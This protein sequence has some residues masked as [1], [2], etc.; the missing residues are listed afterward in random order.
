MLVDSASN[1]T[2]VVMTQGNSVQEMRYDR[3]G[4]VVSKVRNRARISVP[5][6]GHNRLVMWV[7]CQAKGMLRFDLTRG[8]G[9]TPTSHGLL[10]GCGLLHVC[11]VLSS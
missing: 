4:V 8:I 2:P 1:C 9:L 6:C 7:T 3:D 11:R 5:N 10:G